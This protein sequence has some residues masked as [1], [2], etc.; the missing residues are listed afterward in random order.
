MRVV[1]LAQLDDRSGRAVAGRVEIG[2]LD[3][4][5]AAVDAVDHGIGGA[6]QF[7]VEAA[8]KEAADNGIADAFAGEHIVRRST[9]D[10]PLRE[11]PVHALDD[12]AALAERA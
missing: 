3:V 6:L 8:V 5:D 11:R 2:K 7:V 9:F 1:E 12:I 4:M 10:A